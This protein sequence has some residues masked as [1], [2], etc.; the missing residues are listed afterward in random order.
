MHRTKCGLVVFS[1]HPRW[2][3]SVAACQREWLHLVYIH[4]PCVSSSRSFSFARCGVVSSPFQ[5]H[6]R[7]WLRAQMIQRHCPLDGVLHS[8]RAPGASAVHGLHQARVLEGLGHLPG[9]LHLLRQSLQDVVLVHGRGCSVD[10]RP[11]WLQPA[12]SQIHPAAWRMAPHVSGQ[13]TRHIYYT[14]ITQEIRSSV[15]PTAQ[16]PSL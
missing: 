12:H 1:L 15:P 11:H 7:D 14:F 5:T 3:D 6:S 9:V 2:A 10:E 4:Y 13:H 16:T 8:W